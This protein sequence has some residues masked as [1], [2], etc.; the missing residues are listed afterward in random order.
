MIPVFAEY[1]SQAIVFLVYPGLVVF[2]L[3]CL[4]HSH[5]DNWQLRAAQ[6][7]VWSLEELEALGLR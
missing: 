2:T 5:A 4:V 1:V 3:V 7:D 6:R